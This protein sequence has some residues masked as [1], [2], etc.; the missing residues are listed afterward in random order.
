MSSY[1]N[2]QEL[3]EDLLSKL[4]CTASVTLDEESNLLEIET[5]DHAILIGKHGENLRALQYIFNLIRR[6]EFEGSD[7]VAIDVA[8]YKLE[9]IEKVQKITQEAIDAITSTGKP[10]TLPPMNSFERRQAHMVV[11]DN[12]DLITESIG[13]DPHRA[14]VIKKR[15]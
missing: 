6:R 10:V 5:Q 11:A 15:D 14:I 2:S 12:P 3:L 4:G 8:G 9:R 1:A 13:E 7:F